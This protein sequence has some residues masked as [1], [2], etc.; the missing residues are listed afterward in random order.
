MKL[1]FWLIEY[2]ISKMDL[3][4]GK[5]WGAST[6]QKEVATAL[7]LLSNDPKIAI[8]IGGNKGLYTDALL[9]VNPGMEVHIFEPSNYNNLI[10]IKKYSNYLNKLAL[11]DSKEELIMHADKPGSGLASITKRRLDHFNINQKIEEKINAIRFDDYWHRNDLIDIVKI[12][13]EGH[14]LKVLYGMGK[15]LEQTK[16]VQFEFGGCN[17]DTRTYFQDFW[18]FFKERNFSIYRITP[19]GYQKIEKYRE[20]DEFFSGTNYIAMNNEIK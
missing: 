13:V 3:L 4:V 17:I 6:C 19:F 16:L 20:R 14:E 2:L 11:S 7:S 1:F 18:Y 5:G 8:D 9:K 10:L 15:K 12:D